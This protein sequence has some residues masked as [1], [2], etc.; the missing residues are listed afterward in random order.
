VFSQYS[1]IPYPEQLVT[2]IKQEFA[3]MKVKQ[4]E[5][6]GFTAAGAARAKL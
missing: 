1:V 6:L 4:A 3:R 2:Y 5:L